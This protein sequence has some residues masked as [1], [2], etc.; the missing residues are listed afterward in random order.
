MSD[1][2]YVEDYRSGKY[3]LILLGRRF[4]EC[5]TKGKRNWI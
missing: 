4:E 2:K 1:G 5:R 3:I